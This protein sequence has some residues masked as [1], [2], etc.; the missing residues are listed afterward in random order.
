MNHNV[1]L[2]I[3]KSS[4]D[5]Y[6]QNITIVDIMESSTYHCHQQRFRIKRITNF[7]ISLFWK[8]FKGDIN[9]V[10]IVQL[11][12]VPDN[13]Y[14]PQRKSFS[15]L[16]HLADNYIN[17]YDWFVRLDDDAFISWPILE[18]LLRRLDPSQPLYIGK[19]LSPQF[20]ERFVGPS[21]SHFARAL[22][23]CRSQLNC[24]CFQDNR[25]LV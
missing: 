5:D 11:P 7:Y 14:P 2:W 4:Y 15:M 17:K 13:V 10:N 21:I 1:E 18:K 24:K 9:G 16:R 8:H 22:I 19:F 12:G 3:I 23:F 6:H 25:G 20:P